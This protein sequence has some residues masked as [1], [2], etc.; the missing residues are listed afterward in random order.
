VS[1]FDD[2]PLGVNAVSWAPTHHIGGKVAAPAD[3]ATGA[4]AGGQVTVQ[5]LATAGCDGLVRIYRGTPAPAS[6]QQHQQQQYGGP[7]HGGAG[8]E[9]PVVWTLE[10][11]LPGHKDWVRD[12]A[13][14]PTSGLSPNTLASCGDDGTVIVWRQG[15]PGGEWSSEAL[16][17]FPA[18]VWRL[19]WSVTGNLLAVSCGDNSVTL[20]RE[21]LT[22]Q[23]QQVSTVPD[24]TLPPA[25]RPA[26]Y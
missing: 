20:W 7:Q 19:S 6:Q 9:G 10:S 8:G 25:P 18:P 23:M 22:G 13:F 12:V 21:S 5:R 2:C 4:P 17:H 14:A 11:S 24:P 26:G 1:T 3:P 16:P 15:A